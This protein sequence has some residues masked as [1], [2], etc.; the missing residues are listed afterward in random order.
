MNAIEIR[1]KRKLLRLTQ[2][3]LAKK[4]G[5]SLKT[6]SNYEKGEVIPDS[7]K[8]LLH[9]ILNPSTEHILNEPPENYMDVSPNEIEE[10]EELI[11]ERRKIIA[12][13]QDEHEIK[14]QKKVIELLQKQ[15]KLLNMQK[16]TKI[17]S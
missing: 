6:I 5:V 13:A 4:L 17:D 8:E 16:N 9:N 14:H 15:I 3:E 1:E 11:L 12:I 2:E 7:K 10:I